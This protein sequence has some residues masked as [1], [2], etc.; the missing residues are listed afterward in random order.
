[1]KTASSPTASVTGARLA[2]TATTLLLA[3]GIHILGFTANATAAPGDVESTRNAAVQWKRSNKPN[4]VPIVVV[5]SA[6]KSAEQG[7]AEAQNQ[8]GSYY[9]TGSGVPKDGVEAIKWFLK[10]AVQ[11]NAE[12][13]FRLGVCYG[14]GASGASQDLVEAVKW[15]RKAAGQ[16]HASAQ[17]NLGLC[18]YKGDGVPKDDAEAVKWYRKS[19]D[20]GNADAQYDLG[21]CYDSG[22]GVP[23]NAVEAVKWY[24]KSADQGYASAQYHLGLYYAHGKDDVMAYVWLNNAATAGY[25]P[26]KH[27]LIVIS[28]RMTSVQI[29]I[30]KRLSL[31]WQLK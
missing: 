29:T 10:S 22:T 31:E 12:A 4:W 1:M 14:I 28:R 15:F 23:K 24:R 6:R 27:I 5:D 25:L 19:A 16:G 2:P 17:Y 21:V 9:L 13:Q 11:G 7:D 3:L 20:Q 18:Y 8:I 30:A 26:A